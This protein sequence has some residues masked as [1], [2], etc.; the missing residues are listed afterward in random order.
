MAGALKNPKPDA[1]FAL[2]AAP[3]LKTGQIGI[4]YNTYAASSD[5]IDILINGTSCHGARP[6][7]GTDAIIIAA[8]TITA[9]QTII[10]RNINAHDKAVLSLGR[11]QGGNKR[12]IIAEKVGIEGTLRTLSETV[13][14]KI[15][16]QLQELVTTLPRAFGGTGKLTVRPG[17]C[18][19]K[20]DTAMIDHVRQNASRL[21][22]NDA[23]IRT[24][25]PS[26]GV[27]DFAFYL[28]EIPGAI[29]SLGTRG[30]DSNTAF[31]IHTNQ[32]DIDE[33]A[34]PVGVALQVMNVLNF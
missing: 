18:I 4:K 27:E 12:N 33:T 3:G 11:I 23:V 32:F 30:A 16:D 28:K 8:Q 17:A 14:G 25:H 26:M 7:Q 6:F 5:A 20:N 22:G 15:L 10:S 21:L 31:P 2:H 29:Y 24:Q 1:I 34:L 13:R 19:L 9:I